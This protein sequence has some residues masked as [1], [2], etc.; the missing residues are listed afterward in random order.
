MAVDKVVNSPVVKSAAQSAVTGS[1]AGA[2][3]G[4]AGMASILALG[5]FGMPSG[6]A[7]V[8]ASKKLKADR[9]AAAAVENLEAAD[10]TPAGMTRYEYLLSQRPPTPPIRQAQT[11]IY[12]NEE[13]D[14]D[15]QIDEAENY[16]TSPAGKA[17]MDKFYLANSEWYNPDGSRTDYRGPHAPGTKEQTANYAAI[18]GSV[19]E[20]NIYG[21]MGSRPATAADKAGNTVGGN[22]GGNLGDT[23][24][25]S[26]GGTDS[27]ITNPELPEGA[28]FNY[29]PQEM[30]DNEFMTT[31]GKIL[32]EAALASGDDQMVMAAQSVDLGIVDVTTLGTDIPDLDAIAAT[33]NDEDL[34]Q[35]V[36]AELSQR[37]I[38]QEV[39]NRT[40]IE[41]FQAFQ[42]STVKEQYAMLQ[43]DWVGTDGSNKVPF[44]ALGAVTAAKQEVAA[45]GMGGSSMAAAAIT[46]AGLE[47]MMPVAMKDAEFMQT[48]TVKNFDYQT[49][50][51]LAKLSHIANLDISQLNHRQT[52]AVDTANKF[53]QTNM[54][55]VD[56]ER[57]TAATNNANRVQ[58]LFSDVAAEN[59]AA[60]LQYSTEAETDRFFAQLSVQAQEA[61]ARLIQ[62]NEQFNA[63]VINSRQEFNANMS[64]EIERDN[65][66][67][68]R[69]IN[70]A[71][72]AGVNQQNL[73]NT[74]NLLNISNTA[75]ANELTLQRDQLNRIFDA[76]EN[77]AGR[78]N[79]YAIAKLNADSA[80]GRLTSQQSHESSAALGGFLTSIGGSLLSGLG[81]S[82]SSSSSSYNNLSSA[83]LGGGIYS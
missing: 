44:Y 81:S 76:S 21:G 24:S 38:D 15:H 46:Q 51:G 59:V 67:Y 66:T 18:T 55:N 41:S 79:N 68:L 36:Q 49:S 42:G 1:A 83:V 74:Q 7:T 53:F 35:D 78:A 5:A 39:A 25:D 2:G 29:T 27:S 60:N 54:T 40:M 48:L 19:P 28:E 22:V 71:N 10:P 65:L 37:Y 14:K 62:S 33:V 8:D 64:A 58:A 69:S 45:R 61:N 30:A 17:K 77:L 70:T 82:F 32:G 73:T 13:G 12:N 63:S 11:E 56:N 52:M 26:Q 9:Q 20:K 50:M 23:V 80:M 43:D 31:Q 72:T 6:K 47:A 3:S 75:I 4:L 34:I 57:L 16:W